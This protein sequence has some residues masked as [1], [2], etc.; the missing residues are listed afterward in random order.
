MKQKS[1]QCQENSFEGWT[2]WADTGKADVSD[3]KLSMVY[4]F[5]GMIIAAE[6]FSHSR[7]EQQNPV[8]LF[9]SSQEDTFKVCFLALRTILPNIEKSI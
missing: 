3:I 6:A 8:H 9:G 1:K 4:G 5:A 7:G 2:T